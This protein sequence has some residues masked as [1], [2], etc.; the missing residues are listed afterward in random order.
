MKK[1]NPD[2]NLLQHQRNLQRKIPSN[3]ESTASKKAEN[4]RSSSNP[5]SS[6]ALIQENGWMEAI[7]AYSEKM[8][9]KE[10]AFLENLR[11]QSQ[12]KFPGVSQRM[13]SG[14]TQGAFL[15]FLA[16]VT[17]SKFILE[18]GTFTGYSAVCLAMNSADF[19]NKENVEQVGSG[20]QV[21]TC[22]ND[23]ATYNFAREMI[24]TTPYKENVRS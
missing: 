4:L 6:H 18:L 21:F 2:F 19:T 12:G 1:T 23:A 22:E 15:S 8:S 11:K 16:T 13:L 24:E 10:P 20:R 3:T 7:L 9:E 14:P 5:D 17:N